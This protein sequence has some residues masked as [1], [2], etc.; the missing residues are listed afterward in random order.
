MSSY[1]FLFSLFVST[2]DTCY[3]YKFICTWLTFIIKTHIMTKAMD[4]VKNIFLKIFIINYGH[5]QAFEIL[6]I[7]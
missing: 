4:L 6:G 2:K 1:I 3:L 5:L 7:Y